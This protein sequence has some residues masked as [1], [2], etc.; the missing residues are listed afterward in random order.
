MPPKKKDHDVPPHLLG[1]LLSDRAPRERTKVERFEA[2]APDAG[3]RKRTISSK[4]K[5]QKD[6]EDRLEQGEP[7][8]RC[9]AVLDLLTLR[10]DAAWFANPV[11][12]DVIPDYLEVIDTP[13]DYSTVRERLE[14]GA[15]GDD[16]V[17]F[18]ADV[19]VIYTN[20]VTYN[21]RPDHEC[22]KAARSCLRAFE[23]YFGRSRGIDSGTALVQEVKK[24]EK[25]GGKGAKGSDKGAKGGAKKRPSVGG[26]SG[27][28]GGSA[29]A[30]ADGGGGAGEPPKK[31]VRMSMDPADADPAERSAKLL[32]GLSDYLVACGGEP[33][34]VDGWCVTLP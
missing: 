16:V 7:M 9:R 32:Q 10:P 8:D 1:G 13:S 20:A 19:R 18:A 22:H 6:A 4:E 12:V 26:S 25:K 14:A 29:G 2:S 3:P 5:K 11:P 15:Y 24:D 34:M 27:G 33:S 30:S 17:Q 23:H 31:R 28:G 21:W